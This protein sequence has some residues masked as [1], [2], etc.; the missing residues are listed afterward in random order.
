MINGIAQISQ[1]TR[2]ILK[3]VTD[4]PGGQS[5]TPGLRSDYRTPDSTITQQTLP[6][7]PDLFRWSFSGKKCMSDSRS[8]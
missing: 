8:L 1:M 3:S 5:Y 4:P 7:L 2:L 6:A